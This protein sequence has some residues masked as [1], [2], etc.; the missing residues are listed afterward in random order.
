MLHSVAEVRAVEQEGPS[1]G[2]TAAGQQELLPVDRLRHRGPVDRKGGDNSLLHRGEVLHEMWCGRP[3]GQQLPA[4]GGRMP[5]VPSDRP[6]G[7]LLLH[8]FHPDRNLLGALNRLRRTRNLKVS[9]WVAPLCR[10]ICH[11]SWWTQGLV[12]VQPAARLTTG[13]TVP[14]GQVACHT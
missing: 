10:A 4:H 5:L 6:L 11:A 2:E 14:A 9:E 13:I 12:C 3:L 7:P 1:C 8:L